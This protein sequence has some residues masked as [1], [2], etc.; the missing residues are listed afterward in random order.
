MNFTFTE[1]NGIKSISSE[2]WEEQQQP[3]KKQQ[4]VMYVCLF[5]YVF[6]EWWWRWQHDAMMAEGALRVA[7]SSL[8]NSIRWKW[9]Y[10]FNTVFMGHI[11]RKWNVGSSTQKKRERATQKH[12]E[13]K[14]NLSCSIDKV[15]FLLIVRLFIYF[16]FVYLFSPFIFS[17]IYLYCL[18]GNQSVF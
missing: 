11:I 6:V 16:F 18:F 2:M 10:R 3:G 13:R 4:R 5:M 9:V 7:L 12:R 17:F 1:I 8:C 14:T 15:T